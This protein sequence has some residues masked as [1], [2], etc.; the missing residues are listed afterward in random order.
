MTSDEFRDA[1]KKLT[2]D[3]P[4]PWHEAL[5][6]RFIDESTAIPATVSIPTGLG[7]TRVIAVWLLALLHRPHEIPR[8][9]VYVVNRRT[10][11]DQTTEEVQRLRVNLPALGGSLTNLAI[12]TLRG[13]FADN[14][15]W[16][17]DPSK[18]AVVCGTVDMIGS[19]L[20]FSGYRIGFKSRPLH[21]GFL[22]QD[23]LLVHDEAHLEPAFQ[24]LITEI[25]KEQEQEAKRT[26]ELPWPRL[27]VMA[28]SATAG[29]STEQV[30]TKEAKHFELTDEE[31]QPPKVI[32]DPPD[33]PDEESPVYKVWRRL[34]AKKALQ[35]HPCDNE[36]KIAEHIADLAV[37]H[38]AEESAVVIFVRKVDEVTN[39]VAALKKKRV[40]DN[41]IETLTG[42]MRGFER[43]RM[44]DPRRADA[45]CVF[46]RFVPPPKADAS[47]N[48]Q[49]KVE[50][51]QGT[52][53]LVCTSAGEVG[54]N[55][56][57]D[58][59]ICD[60]STFDSM[61]QRLGR[62]NRFGNRDDTRVDVFYPAAFD[63]KHRLTPARQKTLELLQQ[64]DGDASPGALSD[65]TADDRLAAFAPEPRI[66][67]ATDILFDAWAM[68]TIRD[69]MPGRPPVAP[70]LHGVAE[71]EPSRTSVAW[72]DEV[73]RIT[74]E[75]IERNG[76]G[77]PH[78]LLNDYPLKP[79]ELVSDTSE[80]VLACL[81][82]L[83]VKHPETAVWLV[84]KQEG[85]T[86]R[87][88]QEI[89][90]PAATK[91]SDKESL[92]SM[93]ADAVVLLSPSVGGLSAAGMLDGNSSFAEDIA[94]EWPDE[95][96]NARRSRA[97]SDAP[98]PMEVPDGMALVRTVDLSPLADEFA[99]ATNTAQTDAESDL[100]SDVENSPRGRFWHWYTRPRDAE[101]A[102]HASARPITWEH[103]TRDVVKRTMEMS[104]VLKLPDDLKK[105][106][107][108]AAELHDLGKKRE[109]WQRSIGNPTP[110]EWYAKP[111]NPI[112]GR[113]WRPRR[114]SPYRHE[115][116]SLVDAVDKRQTY[117]RNL[118]GLNEQMQDVVLHL[119]AAHHGYARPHFP[120]AATVDP[121][122]PQSVSDEL[123]AEVMRRHARLQR[124]YGR[125]GL[126]YLESLLR[127]ADWTA[128]ASPSQLVETSQD[129]TL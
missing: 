108:L 74:E 40:P 15:E 67:P 52:V 3:H 114:L 106:V 127:A 112:N 102:T 45:S 100:S 10:V 63:E 101:D 56:S 37:H 129:V 95:D 14:Q 125:W 96:G 109:L 86:V 12:S 46:A 105:A 51:T 115:F 13:Q 68:T 83:A 89:A 26:G 19:R 49:W 98:K 55:L 126:A 5:Y 123:A 64:L 32:P 24:Q 44:A 38:Q 36:K 91:K 110:T 107:I 50:P 57:A 58:H 90:D 85:V 119:V 1:F 80:R 9:L 17:A 20:L 97:L 71:W 54:V 70:Y 76:L 61:A 23:A 16:S 99:P 21:A 120:P 11:V 28:L 59:L 66:L 29:S 103:H 121:S 94:D 48:E 27:R 88:L 31:K 93:I 122:H 33:D 65:L 62:V 84:D 25:E 73:E 8:R 53:Y 92:L 116:G 124:R 39:V 113:A 2:G 79:H 69:E 87:T 82:K 35:L 78:E 30:L 72:R 60:L 77:F 75:L 34:K 128:S 81:Q 118:A 18:P 111:G 7:K 47:E 117:A 43:D 41:H 104:Q 4:F 42:T 22:G 6:L